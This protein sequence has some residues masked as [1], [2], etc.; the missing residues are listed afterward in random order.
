MHVCYIQVSKIKISPPTLSVEKDAGNTNSVTGQPRPR[1]LMPAG[2]PTP[3]GQII[4]QDGVLQLVVPAQCFNQVHDAFSMPRLYCLYKCN[5]ALFLCLP[6]GS[7]IH[8]QVL[9]N[10]FRQQLFRFQQEQSR[11][12]QKP[13]PISNQEFVHLIVMCIVCHKRL[14]FQI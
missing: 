10:R 8:R 7:S 13:Y 3:L 12:I 9:D 1:L 6:Y 2:V 5:V 4:T 11:L 14:K